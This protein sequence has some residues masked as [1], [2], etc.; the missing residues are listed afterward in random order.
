VCTR[1]SENLCLRGGK[2]H[3]RP[4]AA[5]S[6]YV[7]S[8]TSA[9]GLV[10]VWLPA[11]SAGLTTTSERLA[12]GTYAA[13]LAFDNAPVAAEACAEVPLGQP[14]ICPPPFNRGELHGL[15]VEP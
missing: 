13:R 12:D 11:G 15:R 9:D 14:L 10:L 4:G 1:S 3:V 5:A 6:G 2:R 7:V 8:A